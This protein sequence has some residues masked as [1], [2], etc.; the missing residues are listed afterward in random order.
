MVERRGRCGEYGRGIGRRAQFQA[1]LFET[2]LVA[3]SIPWVNGQSIGANWGV[4]LGREGCLSVRLWRDVAASVR[5]RPSDSRCLANSK[6][7]SCRSPSSSTPP[8][9][10]YTHLSHRR[11]LPFH[12]PRK[13]MDCNDRFLVGHMG[14]NGLTLHAGWYPNTKVGK[15]LFEPD[16][17][18]PNT[19]L[20]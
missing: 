10:A 9:D 7:L 5:I 11:E 13:L 16:K 6:F 17:Y 3:L 20:S 12:F 15:H 19:V 4:G 8:K 1:G 2:S 18:S 14:E